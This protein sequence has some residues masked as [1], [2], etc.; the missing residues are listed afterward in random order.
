MRKRPKDINQLAKMLVGIATGQIE[1]NDK[2]PA[3]PVKQS[4]S[5][6]KTSKTKKK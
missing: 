3:K 2:T 1:D 4:N 6:A 5:K